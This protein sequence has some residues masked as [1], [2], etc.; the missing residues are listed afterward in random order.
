MSDK[1][2]ERLANVRTVSSDMKSSDMKSS[3]MKKMKLL[4][5]MDYIVN[6][7]R[8][9]DDYDFRHSWNL[10]AIPVDL[11]HLIDGIDEEKLKRNEIY[12]LENDEIFEGAFRVG[13]Q[14][15]VHAVYPKEWESVGPYLHPREG[16]FSL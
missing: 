12:G 9:Y 11:G 14:S 15:L 10:L 16:I 1:R 3:D 7:I 5:C 4:M 2:E 8:S 6:H 13:V